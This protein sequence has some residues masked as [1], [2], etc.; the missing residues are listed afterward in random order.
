MKYMLQFGYGRYLA[1]AEGRA[2]P[3]GQPASHGASQGARGPASQQA[4]QARHWR[5]ALSLA[6]SIG[7]FTHSLTPLRLVFLFCPR[8]TD[9]SL[10]QEQ[11]VLCVCVCVCVCAVSEE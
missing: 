5:G 7:E 1:R 4:R 6:L 11:S 2:G 8:R 9:G 3:A 10:Q